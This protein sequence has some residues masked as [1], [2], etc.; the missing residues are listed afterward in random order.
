MWQFHLVV[1]GRMNPSLIIWFRGTG[2][3][4]RGSVQC[5]RDFEIQSVLRCLSLHYIGIVIYLFFC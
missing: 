4:L 5:I 2:I 3:V 1:V